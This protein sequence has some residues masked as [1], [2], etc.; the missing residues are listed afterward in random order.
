MAIDKSKWNKNIKV[1]QKTIDEIKKMGMTKALKTAAG[2]GAAGRKVGD[3]SAKEWAEGLRRLYTPERVDK[4]MG[5]ASKA[6]KSG[7][8]S[9]NTKVYTGP[10]KPAGQY[11]KGAAKST[12]KNKGLS[13]AQKV[14][15]TGAAAAALIASRGR[16]AGLA[17]RLAPGLAKSGVG[18]ALMGPDMKKLAMANPKLKE[19]AASAAAKPKAAS[20]SVK[21]GAKGSFGPTTKTMA[22]S[23]LGTPSEYA[24]RAAQFGGPS[25]I[26]IKKAA[27]KKAAIKKAS[28]SKSTPSNLR[29]EIKADRARKI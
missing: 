12:P 19:A 13:T 28:F 10:K 11:T 22:K 5:S 4:L 6:A 21:T 18:K 8:Q 9:A 14:V 23:K 27:A 15:G 26:T 25:N 24:S 1:S 17:S 2:A 20:A 3:A 16:A 7:P 29:K